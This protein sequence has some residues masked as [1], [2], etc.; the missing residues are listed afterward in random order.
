MIKAILFDIDDTVLD[1]K[2]C[3]EW[4]IKTAM[5]ERGLEYRHDMYTVFKK[6][7]DGL[8]EQLEAGAISREELSDRRFCEVFAELEISLDGLEFERRFVELLHESCEEVPFAR[9]LIIY[10]HSK[11]YKIYAVSNA[12][13]AQQENRLNKGGLAE[14]FDGIFTSE[15]F[16][17]SKPSRKF[18]DAFFERVPDLTKTEVLLIGDSLSADI[19]GGK[20]YGMTTCWFNNGG[21]SSSSGSFSDFVV[22]SLNSVKLFM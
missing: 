2:K 22:T 13:Q 7:N 12:M 14:Y 16:N 5:A 6:I 8:W 20:K 9:D 18:F 4:A 17:A 10:L 1:F 19:S 11:G 15:L 21:K 3:A